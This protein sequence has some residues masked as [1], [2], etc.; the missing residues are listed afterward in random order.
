[1][2]KK[3]TNQQIEELSDHFW[4]NVAN[5]FPEIQSGDLEPIESIRLENAIEQ[6]VN[7]W[8]KTNHR[9]GEK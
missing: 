2:T 3:I 8:L 5:M 6:A 7:A 1:M 9:E 4:G